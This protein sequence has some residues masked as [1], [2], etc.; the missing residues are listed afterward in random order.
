MSSSWS[1]ACSSP[2]VADPRRGTPT[3]AEQSAL[4][5]TLTE[6]EVVLGLVVKSAAMGKVGDSDGDTLADPTATFEYDLLAWQITG[7]PNWAKTKT[8][9]PHQDP[10]TR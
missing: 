9:E 1:A 3:P 5:V 7:K 6:A 8:R 10:N 4:H 2:N